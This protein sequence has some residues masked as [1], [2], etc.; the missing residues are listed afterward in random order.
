MRL[1]RVAI[2]TD[3]VS[4]LVMGGMQKHSY[5]LLRY[6]LSQGVHV[7]LFHPGKGSVKEY[8]PGG[9]DERLEEHI[10]PFPSKGSWPWSYVQNSF[11]YS[12]SLYKRLQKNQLPIDFIYAQGFTAWHLLDQKRKK[13]GDLPPVGVNFHGLEMFQKANGFK[14]K[15]IQWMFRGPVKFN[16]SQ[17]DVVYSLGGG[18]SHILRNMKEVDNARIS[19]IP[20]G[21]EPSWLRE[22]EKVFP[23]DSL[24]F[25]F[26][27]RYERRKGI[28]D[29]NAV[30]QHLEG[31]DLTFEFI[32]PIPHSK[33]IKDG[34]V[35]YH[36]AIKVESELIQMI[37]QNHVLVV[38][39]YSEGMPTVILEAMARGLVVI[40]SR[41][42]AVED[43]VDSDIGQL[44]DPGDR[45]GLRKAVL[46][47]KDWSGAQLSMMSRQAQKRFNERFTWPQ[48][49]EQTIADIEKR[50]L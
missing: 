25:L 37:D 44:V 42:G 7:L 35:T 13:K 45:E 18:L 28:E 10:V 14:Q 29:W 50:F 41:V 30:I 43:Q 15:V 47:M 4:P 17:A 6:F 21:L 48:V 9:G 11:A 16:L 38:P 32:G 23:E 39:S 22:E 31:E 8:L 34:R 24:S 27:G 1:K 46:E 19:E 26:I 40:A 2:L 49:I 3:G 5:Y 20:I 33:R 36:G 12:V